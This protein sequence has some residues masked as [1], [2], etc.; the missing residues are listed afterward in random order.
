MRAKRK[1]KNINFNYVEL[2][3]LGVAF[4]DDADRGVISGVNGLDLL[5]RKESIACLI[6]LNLEST[7]LPEDVE[8]V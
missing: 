3:C 5:D 1:S 7:L 2:D 4:G 6:G 8:V